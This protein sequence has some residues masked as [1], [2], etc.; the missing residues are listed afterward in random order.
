MVPPKQFHVNSWPLWPYPVDLSPPSSF[1]LFSFSVIDGNMLIFGPHRS[2]DTMWNLWIGSWVL[3]IKITHLNSVASVF[4]TSVVSV[5][6][7]LQVSHLVCKCRILTTSVASVAN[8]ILLSCLCHLS[9]NIISTLKTPRRLVL[10][11]RN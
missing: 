7:C 9:N 4:I 2:L 3:H 11:K 10:K 1:S 8:I 6:S 5:A